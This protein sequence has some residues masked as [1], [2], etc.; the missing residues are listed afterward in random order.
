M[1]AALDAVDAAYE[2]LCSTSTDGVGAAFRMQVAERLETLGRRHL[3][4]SYR[5][6]GEICDPPDGPPE[7]GVKARLARELRVNRSEVDRRAK[8][9]ARVRGRRVGLGPETMEPELPRLAA[10][11]R[12]G[13]VGEGHVAEVCRALDTLPRWVASVEKRWA[14]RTLV[15]H[16]TRQDPAFVAVVGRALDAKL[17]PDGVF[18]ERDRQARRDVRM[19][20]QGSD[21]MSMISGWLT[22]EA[23][24]YVEAISAA[25]RPGHHVP[26]TEQTVVDAATD[27]RTPGQ[28]RHDALVWGMRT[29]LESGNLG[30]HRGIAVTVIARTTVQDLQQAA[31]AVAD[32][33]VPMPPPATTGGGS[34]LPM[35]ELIAMAA[36]GSMPYLAV[37]DDHSDRPLYL[38][39]GQRL[40]TA[41]QR[42][43]CHARDRGCT[44]PGCTV[45]GYG[46][47][48]HHAPAWVP[49]GPG[50]ADKLFFACGPDNRAEARGDV[51]TV[52]T[53]EGRLGW[54]DG[55]GPPEVNRIHHPEE[56]LGDDDP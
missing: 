18:D 55:T 20:P 41:D 52:V 16:A 40:A 7:R 43:I 31:R 35:R 23:R 39:R 14:E 48:V 10:A 42:I 34:R 29:A 1:L 27:S 54:S 6:V 26:D 8:V 33:S 4:L 36:Q 45:P 49:G 38:A 3:G 25:V 11:L 2:R 24:A 46:C 5:M 30:T 13:L 12:D 47:E 17:N 15:G 19:G 53:D 44:R 28:R 51:R 37:F 9:A 50:D 32:P 56:L 21:G 22:P